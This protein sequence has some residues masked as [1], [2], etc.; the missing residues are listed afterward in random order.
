VCGIAGLLGPNASLERVERMRSCL[1]HRGPDDRGIFVEGELALAH[2]R[3]CVIDPSEAGQQP[4]RTPEGRHV[5]V[6]NG[7]VYNYR[8]IRQE[9]RR[10]GA[11]F[12]SGT[13]TEVVLHALVRWGE[14]ALERFEGMFA[15]AL[16]DTETE[17][18]LLAR[19]RMGIKP[20]Y[21]LTDTRGVLLFASEIRP[22]LESGHVPR[23]LDRHVL[24]DFLSQQTTP[25]PGTLVESVCSLPPGHLARFDGVT[26]ETERYAGIP[27]SVGVAPHGDAAEGRTR[28]RIAMETAVERR[29]MSDVPLGAFLS[30]GVDST[31]IVGL[32]SRLAS[33]PP[34][35]FTLVLDGHESEDV[36]YAR[37]VADR[38][39]TDHREVRVSEHDLL[40]QVTDALASQDHP[41]GDGLNTYLVSRAAREAGLTVALSGVGG[42]ELFGGYAA[43]FR[44]L[45][46]A[47]RWRA[48]WKLA[49]ASLRRTVGMAAYA[50]HPSVATEA[51]KDLVESDGSLAEVY[52]V[53]RGIF[54]SPQIE[55]LL[56]GA[57]GTPN[58]ASKQV[59]SVLER[60]AIRSA[61]E[62]ATLAEMSV[63]MRDVLLR[64]ADQMGMANSLEIRVP[65]LDT[66]VVSAALEIGDRARRPTEPPKR[67]LT[68]VFDDLVPAEVAHRSKE[69][70]T[71]P[72]ERWMR[73]ELRDTCREAIG[74]LAAHPAFSGDE[75]RAVWD[76]F[77][78]GDPRFTWSRPWLLVALGTWVERHSLA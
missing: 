77:L 16:F 3:L 35:T 25:T 9:L 31:L 63:Y 38:F 10:A 5:L 47:R 21:Y 41:T 61:L 45:H 55:R 28:L 53:L 70:F 46:R 64:D 60:R 48:L 57:P 50:V 67:F 74:H 17:R 7:E 26:F 11:S 39:G 76:G 75:V 19:D 6:Y 8:E 36:G 42:D 2:T 4:M 58:L 52:P 62:G 44:R 15:L 51:F 1:H 34:S 56:T 12:R 72:M 20:L 65:F 68:D 40:E 14:S 59:A 78:D 49:P 13:D 73:V 54:F 32:M 27:D 43:T 29:L 37:R 30:G 22:L 23:R 66:D 24:P 71:L 33:E 69:G 18:L